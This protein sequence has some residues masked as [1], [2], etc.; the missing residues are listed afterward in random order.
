MV[1]EWDG[2][3]TFVNNP[4]SISPLSRPDW[5]DNIKMAFTKVGCEDMYW[6]YQV[7]DRIQTRGCVDTAG[8]N[9]PSCGFHR[10]W[11]NS[12]LPE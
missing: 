2:G 9:N 5:E 3:S 7:P 10:R 4:G 11:I 8:P 12:G 6:I 1:S